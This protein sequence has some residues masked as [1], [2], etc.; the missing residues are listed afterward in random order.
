MGFENRRSIWFDSK[1]HLNVVYEGPA[2]SVDYC[3]E[4][5]D[6]PAYRVEVDPLEG[7]HVPSWQA[8]DRGSSRFG[9]RA[10]MY[11]PD[12]TWDSEPGMSYTLILVDATAAPAFLA[13]EAPGIPDI[14]AES[15][16]IHSMFTNCHHGN[17]KDCA[18]TVVP[19]MGPGAPSPMV[20]FNYIW[21]LYEGSVQPDAAQLTAYQSLFGFDPNRFSEEHG[22]GPAVGMSWFY[23]AADESLPY[24]YDE[25]WQ[26]ALG[27]S[28]MACPEP[29]DWQPILA[30]CPAFWG[31]VRTCPNENCDGVDPT[32]AQLEAICFDIQ[33]A[34]LHC[35]DAFMDHASEEVHSIFSAFQDSCRFHH[36]IHAPANATAVVAGEF[37][38]NHACPEGCHV[39]AGAIAPEPGYLCPHDDGSDWHDDA[40]HGSDWQDDGAHGSDGWTDDSAHGSD[41]WTDDGAHGSDWH[42]DHGSHDTSN[43][44]GSHGSYGGHHSDP[45][46]ATGCPTRGWIGDAVCDSA[47]YNAACMWDGD[48]HMDNGSGHGSDASTDHGSDQHNDHGSDANTDHG[49]DQ[50]NGSDDQDSDEGPPPC[51]T[52]A[53]CPHSPD[54]EAPEWEWCAWIKTQESQDCINACDDGTRAYIQDFSFN[55]STEPGPCWDAYQTAIVGMENNC[56]KDCSHECDDDDTDCTK[57]DVGQPEYS[58]GTC[59]TDE[60]AGYFS[61][62][63]DASFANVVDAM[64]QD[65]G[66][67]LR[68]WLNHVAGECGVSDSLALTDDGASTSDGWTDDGTHGSD[69]HMDD[70]SGHGSDTSTDHGSDQHNDHGSDANTDHGSDQH[71]DHGSDSNDDGA[72]DDGTT[73]HPAGSDDGTTHATGSDD[74][75]AGSDWHDDGAAGSDWHDDGDAKVQHHVRKYLQENTGQPS[76]D[77]VVDHLLRTHKEYARRDKSQFRKTV[78]KA[79][80]KCRESTVQSPKANLNG[81]AKKP[82]TQGP[83]E[84][85]VKP[86]AQISLSPS[87]AISNG[88]RPTARYSDVGGIDA[89]LKEVRQLIEYPITHPEIYVHLGV[90]PPR[91]ILLHGPPGCGKT[92]LANAV[93]GELGRPFIKI[94]APE[95]VSGTSGESEQKLR[96]LFEEAALLAPCILFIDEIDA[97]TPKR[98]S[99]QRGME[100]RI[101]AQLLTC[102][103]S[104][105]MENTNSQAVVVIGATNR[106]D[107]IDPA[108]RRAGRF[109]REIALGIPD[110]AARARILQAM[111][112]GMRLSGDFDFGIIARRTPGFVGADLLSVAKEA[113]V[114]AVN[115]NFK[116]IFGTGAGLPPPAALPAAAEEANAGKNSGGGS[117]DVRAGD[118]DGGVEDEDEDEGVKEHDARAHGQAGA[119]AEAHSGSSNE[120]AEDMM[121]TSPKQGINGG[122]S[123]AVAVKSEEGASASLAPLCLTMGDFLEAVSKVQPSAK[124]EGFAT[125]PDVS[126][127]DIGA[128]GSVR[129]QLEL[130]IVQP[131]SHPERFE[132]LGLTM[133]AGVLLHGP[134]G[135]GKTLLAKAIARESGANFISIKGPELLDKFVGESERAVRQ[136]FTRARASSPCVVFFD[137]LDALCPRRG[138]SGEASGVSERVVNQL[139][140]ELDGAGPS[141]RNVFVIAATNRPDIIDPAML[142]PGR[143]DKILFVPLPQ[144]SERPQIL[145]TLTG[146]GTGTGSASKNKSEGSSS[147]NGGKSKS[148][149]KK[150]PL[151][152]DVDLEKIALDE[153]CTGFS[154]A[155]LAALVREA[156]ISALKEMMQFE[157]EAEAEA[158]AEA[159]KKG[160][161]QE[162]QGQGQKRQ[163]Q[164]MRAE[165]AM[166]HFENA[167]SRV[168]PSVSA[169]DNQQ[170]QQ[171]ASSLNNSRASL[172]SPRSRSRD[173]DRSRRSSDH[174]SGGSD[175][176]GSGGAGDEQPQPKRQ[177]HL[178]HWDD[179]GISPHKIHETHA[180]MESDI[181]PCSG[182]VT[183]D[184]NGTPC[185]GFRQCGSTKGVPGG[186]G[187]DVPLEIR[188]ATNDFLTDWSDPIWLYDMFYYRALPYDPVRP[189]IDTDGS[190]YSA[191]STDG[192]NSTTK[193][194]PCAAGGRLDLW[195]SPA[196][197]GD[198]MNWTYIRPMFTTSETVNSKTAIS[199][200]FVTSGYFGFGDGGTTRVVTQNNAGP[201]YWIGKQSNGSPFVVDWTSNYSTGMY[202][203]G[204][205]TMAR[206]LGADPNQVTKAGRRV[207]VGWMGGT[208]ASQS[209]ARDLTLGTT[210]AGTGG[211]KDPILLQ[212][213]VPELKVLRSPSSY[214]EVRSAPTDNK[215]TKPEQ[216]A[217]AAV[218]TAAT[219]SLRMEI[220][221]TFTFDPN[222]QQPFG[223]SVLGSADGNTSQKITIDCSKK[224]Q[225]PN[226]GP[227]YCTASCGNRGHSSGPLL[228]EPDATGAAVSDAFE[229]TATA[230]ASVHV[231]VDHSILE[232]IFSNRTAM[233]VTNVGGASEDD[234]TVA[235][236]GT[237][238]GTTTT[239][240]MQSWNL[241]AAN[242][243]DAVPT[244]PHPMP[245]PP[246]PP[247]PTPIVPSYPGD[248]WI[249]PK[250]HNSPNCLHKGGWHDV[251]GALS[252]KDTHHVFQGCPGDG[253]WHHSAS[254]DLVHWTW[255]GIAPHAI[256]ESHAGME[257]HDSPC[258]GFVTVDDSGTPCA[259]FRQCGSSKGVDGGQKWDVPLEI[260]CATNSDLTNW[261]DP[262]WLYDVFF[263]RG[264]PYDP[265]RPWK[266][267][268]GYWYSGIST[269]GC[270]ATK[271]HGCGAGGQL[272]LWRSKT[273]MHG[274]D[275][276]WEKIE[277]PMFTSNKSYPLGVG[278]KHGEFVT[279]DYFG[280][281]PG[282]PLG[283]KTRV[284]TAN[285][286]PRTTYYMGTQSNGG[287][288]TVDFSKAGTL[289]VIDHAKTYTMARTLGDLTNANQVSVNGRRVIVGWI[290]GGSLASQSLA[291]DVTLSKESF[292]LQQFVPE[293]KTL[294]IPESHTTATM[295]T[296]AS[297]SAT[298]SASAGASDDADDADALKPMGQQLEVFA[299]FQVSGWSPEPGPGPP[300]PGPSPI[301]A[302][303][304]WQCFLSKGAYGAVDTGAAA[305]NAAFAKSP[306]KI[307]RRECASCDQAS[308]KTIFYKRKTPLGSLDLYTTLK[309]AW[310]DKGN[311]L[312]TDFD[313]FSAFADATAGKNPW[314]FW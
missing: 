296:T 233:A 141:R 225:Y 254:K 287:P 173:R 172:S 57:C 227:P 133:P 35:R 234:T 116:S 12:I 118:K 304:G 5:H 11:T 96:E 180:G 161:E 219:G 111:S 270:N 285:N 238:A 179:R 166:R 87:R 114:I 196:L 192:C 59:K 110:E 273:S 202:D 300:G 203:H 31:W 232:C 56:H 25:L 29:T 112:T 30:A 220:Y 75:A 88:E 36:C 80:R 45:C 160:Q 44:H 82:R 280:G 103:D 9:A 32:A 294:R 195:K 13:W 74:G 154:G 81:N 247:P 288:L 97:V 91:G 306:T 71:N 265:I 156:G 66:A 229:G 15:F 263:Y 54:Q 257:S 107:A 283:G 85:E 313:L 67:Q 236:F 99:S 38:S 213:F 60:C 6:F 186:A 108:L 102:M 55:C 246:T 94:S 212:Q 310:T 115:R 52:H 109:D 228:P 39:A 301:P 252:W 28:P 27:P 119:S 128:L 72:N 65:G 78:K 58:Q 26:G 299:K 201:T 145:R 126:F 43:D 176:G 274:P 215:N 3:G 191:M 239:A 297:A 159:E 223:V 135:C 129:A 185:A 41:G 214:R 258:S 226:R 90:E 171:M 83:A 61:S 69:A 290:G 163:G 295:S 157:M 308:H 140:T 24:I 178:V 22:L 193:K 121:D 42:D 122:G 221:A 100:R 279:S 218:T 64:A 142:R 293:F 242:N 259:G 261:S 188:C 208:P 14:S 307:V 240:K 249:A 314:S 311:A 248:P 211:R 177:K 231:I 117:A 146:H 84:L 138:S 289:G 93:A 134:P 51:L 53:H 243:P 237:G 241:Q 151:A 271:K 210:S 181:T 298:T 198:K 105:S 79:M 182:F 148:R 207:L 63:T 20:E 272:D 251:A 113:A 205:L 292:L 143:L 309:K 139:L 267:D 1:T 8:R 158:E 73:A 216:G 106:P 155:D 153:R 17:I 286:D 190:W 260:R 217:T 245:P 132:R 10:G 277:T 86:P 49:S 284:F 19:Y 70:G 150:M 275:M 170:Y 206:T 262:I 62:L 199:A 23:T 244:P 37:Y 152:L 149:N 21:I 4:T 187:W 77:A 209:L 136:V 124:R 276:A 101:V 264:L 46:L 183:V 7:T 312:H 40:A 89:V 168:R 224:S 194:R 200:E 2:E 303:D 68:S 92:L 16:V 167:L 147:S 127:A 76:E 123:S 235:L 197:H 175:G 18:T 33:D 98:D 95:I 137:E 302:G 253:G 184:D 47:C 125:T 291:R 174:H 164:T 204:S 131:I 48:A 130:S 50:H 189:W 269:D 165:V 162:G 144:P 282:D 255:R 169:S 278:V 230:T 256:A 281:I 250:V 266:D 120:K 34:S 222:T 305:F 268:D 104:L